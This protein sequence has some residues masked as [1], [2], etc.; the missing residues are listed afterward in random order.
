M[1]FFETQCSRAGAVLEVAVV[2]WASGDWRGIY[3]SIILW[4]IIW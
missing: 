3:T 2:E 1:T 4:L